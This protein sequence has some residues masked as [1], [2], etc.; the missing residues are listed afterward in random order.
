MKL[1]V[2]GMTCQGC[3]KAVTNSVQRAAPGSA[4]VV[5]L[6]GGSVEITGAV[7]ERVAR[8]AIER[9][10]FNVTARIA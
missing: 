10:G 4:V 7:E 1:A 9:A 8:Q 3:A 6:A 2:S 5:D